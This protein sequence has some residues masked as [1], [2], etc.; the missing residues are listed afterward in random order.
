[1]TDT[2]V[3]VTGHAAD[4]APTEDPAQSTMAEAVTKEGDDE[5]YDLVIARPPASA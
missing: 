3:T 2:S 4:G 1:M 5:T